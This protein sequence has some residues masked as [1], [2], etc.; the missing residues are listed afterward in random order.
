MS[1]VS[2]DLPSSA[3]DTKDLIRYMYRLAQQLNIALSG[4]DAT[5]FS[6]GLCKADRGRHRGIR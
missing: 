2:F 6:A 3:S 4:I 1:K 5:N